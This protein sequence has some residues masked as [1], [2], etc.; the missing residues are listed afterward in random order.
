MESSRSLVEK[1]EVPAGGTAGG[2][3]HGL[4]RQLELPPLLVGVTGSR[5]QRG[6]RSDH[7]VTSEGQLLEEV[8][9]PGTNGGRLVRRLEEDGLEVDAAL[10]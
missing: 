8:E 1:S 2:D 7:R 4:V 3:A 6:G 5:M 9:D 10:A